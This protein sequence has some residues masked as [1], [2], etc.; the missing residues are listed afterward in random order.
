M[1]LTK[2]EVLTKEY[3]ELRAKILELG[4]S[5]DRLDRAEGSVDGDPR[6]TLLR[7][8]LEELSSTE[9]GRAERIQLLF[10]LPYDED[11]KSHFDLPA[12]G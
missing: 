4:A 11:W 6:L 10:S 9:L 2:P 5:F 12:G 7:R 8:G 1:A 3:L